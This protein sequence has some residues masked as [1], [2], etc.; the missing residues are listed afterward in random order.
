MAVVRLLTTPPHTNT[1]L[2]HIR[3]PNSSHTNCLGSELTRVVCS[4]GWS[5]QELP[6]LASVP[7]VYLQWTAV[8]PSVP[9]LYSNLPQCA[10]SVPTVYC[11][12]QQCTCS[13]PQCTAIYPS[14]PGVYPQCTATAGCLYIWREG[15]HPPSVLAF[16][17]PLVCP[18]AWE[19]YFSF[20]QYLPYPVIFCKILTSQYNT[21]AK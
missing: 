4:S 11:N 14:V 7:A 15:L 3:P 9:T 19:V 13:V 18:Y 21:V 5:T 1:A 8:Y 16:K 10:C 17:H 12:L 20:F 6:L 2:D